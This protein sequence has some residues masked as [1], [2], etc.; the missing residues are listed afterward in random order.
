MKYGNTQR[1]MVSGVPILTARK[2]WL[3]SH[4]QL[5]VYYPPTSTGTKPPILIFAYGG[6]FTSG[7]RIRPPPAD[8]VYACVGAFFASRGLLTVI[9]DYRL[10]PEIKF[11]QPVEDVRDALVFAVQHLGHACD[12]DNIFLY[13]HSAGASIM[14]SMFLHEPALLVDADVRKRVKGVVSLGA[15]FVFEGPAT[16]TILQYYGD[17]YERLCP[18]GL[19]KNASKETLALLPPLYVMRSEK[20]PPGLVVSHDKF[21]ELLR[22]RGVK[23]VKVDIAQGHNHISPGLALSSG[24]GEEWGNNL[25]SWVKQHLS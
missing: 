18:Y 2:Y 11:P 14:T 12:T 21:V 22:E 1:H 19:L 6:G 8:L 17:A 13:G 10:L 25:V 7:E 24:E 23:D 5:D 9:P 16:Q 20:E 4:L 3:T 15:P